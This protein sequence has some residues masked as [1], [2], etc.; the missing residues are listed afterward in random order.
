MK[1]FG[2]QHNVCI[3]A[4]VI[5]AVSLLGFNAYGF[6]S[7][8]SKPL[9]TLP[10]EVISLREKLAR[11][12]RTLS[13]NA[14]HAWGNVRESAHLFKA[15]QTSGTMPQS[16]VAPLSKTEPIVLPT[17][18]GI[19]RVEAHSNAPYFMAVLGG[20]VCREQDRVNEFV[21]GRITAEGAVL[22]RQGSEWFL[23]SPAPYYS[24]DQGE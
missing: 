20:R 7:L 22:H 14:L 1:M 16:E 11:L 18:S 17:L 10:A 3:C 24:S 8:E 2:S 9:G 6:L 19:V 15:A 12:E 5:A 21:V 13:G 4:W 23:E